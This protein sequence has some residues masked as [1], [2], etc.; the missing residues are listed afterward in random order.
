M[1]RGKIV[2]GLDIGTTKVCA[3]VA[4]KDE[5]GKMN[6]LGMGRSN[7]EGL[8][9]ATVININKTVDAIKE[10]VSEAEHT[11]SIKI[12]GVN[13]GIS[14]E[15]VQFVRGNA[16]VSINPLGIVNHAD[17]LRF[18]EK[19]KKN[20]K[21]IDIDREIIHAIPQEFIV[22]DQEGVLDPIGMAGIS[23]KG[24]VYVVVGMKMRIR[25]IEHCIAHAGLEIKAMTFEP[26]AS[27]LAVIKESER[28]SGVVVIDIGGGTTDIAIYSRGVIRHS[29]VIKVAAVDVTND[30][31]IGLKTLHEIAEDL[32]VKHGCAYMREL[33][34]DEEIQVQG[35]EG[36]PPKNFMRSAL[37]NIIEAR[38]IEIFELVRAELK[39]SGFY[40]YLNAGAIIT[41]GGSLIPGTQGLAQEIL[42]L[43]VRIG[44]PEG[45]SGGIKKDI[46][47]PMYA[48]VMG[49][50][51]HAFDDM[52]QHQEQMEALRENERQQKEIAAQIDAPASDS[53]DEPPESDMPQNAKK[54]DKSF[55]LKI[56]NWLD[57]I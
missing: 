21:Y 33:M 25:N 56:K 14:G 28:K 9:R 43:D 45:I 22:D 39:K 6:I 53:T 4:E 26:I 2:V 54:P 38:M 29:G 37:T 41:G 10:A 44:Y 20:L 23:M 55:L 48:T 51:A 50:V 42:G 18:V 31:A 1:S 52:E 19:A 35:I 36:R 30:V 12:K 5:F 46:N 24:S 49:L 57:Q 40:D 16:E 32:K 11:S 47:N 17:V 8:Q 34:N 7:S 3:V 15:H 13:V 27:G